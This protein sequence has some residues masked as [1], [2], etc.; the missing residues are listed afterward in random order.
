MA[1]PNKSTKPFSTPAA[2]YWKSIAFLAI[3]SVPL[4]PGW[5]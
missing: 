4:L 2:A 5:L 3:F 1:K